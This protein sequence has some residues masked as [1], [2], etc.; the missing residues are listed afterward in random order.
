MLQQP[1]ALGANAVV[2]S[3]TKYIG[4]HSD[5]LMGAIIVSDAGQRDALV[6]WRTLHGAIPGVMEAYLALR[7]L[8]TLPVRF[9]RRQRTAAELA[10]RLDDHRHVALVRYRGLVTDPGFDRPRTLMGG[11][12]AV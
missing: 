5:L 9:A 4:G 1:L 2:H 8:R 6:E 11:F 7:G 3:A 10:E 12:R